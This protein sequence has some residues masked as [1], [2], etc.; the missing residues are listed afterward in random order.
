MTL[1]NAITSLQ[2]ATGEG[3]HF[4]IPKYYSFENPLE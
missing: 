1:Y 2:G 4:P 3:E